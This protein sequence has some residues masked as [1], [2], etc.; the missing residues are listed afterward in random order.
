MITFTR[1][2]KASPNQETSTSPST[3]TTFENLSTP[4][5]ELSPEQ[6]SYN[7]HCYSSVA[8]KYAGA[9]TTI[10]TTS[11]QYSFDERDNRMTIT[12]KG[13]SS[14]EERFQVLRPSTWGTNPESVITATF[15]VGST[16]CPD[17][18][19]ANNIAWAT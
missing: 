4:F 19:A 12:M 13:P 17:W 7:E 8:E 2:Q 5:S 10:G 11:I 9:T 15:Q 1:T 6:S 18:N 3:D 14:P 16:E